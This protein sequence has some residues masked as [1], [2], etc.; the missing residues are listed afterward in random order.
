MQHRIRNLTLTILVA[1]PLSPSL[2]A[3]TARPSGG[4]TAQ[5]DLSGIWQE[6]RVPGGVP[7]GV[8]TKRNPRCFLGPAR[9]RE[10]GTGEPG[11]R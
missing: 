4:T 8:F 1:L 2:F 3:Q 9:D 5:P 7:P 10:S 6:D 11:R